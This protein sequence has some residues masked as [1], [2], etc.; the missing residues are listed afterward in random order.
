MPFGLFN[1]PA[2][3]L[4]YINKILAKKFDIFVIVYLDNILIYTY[5]TVNLVNTLGWLRGMLSVNGRS[6][7]I[8]HVL[9]L[10]I[11]GALKKLCFWQ[12]RKKVF[13]QLNFASEL[14]YTKATCKGHRIRSCA[15]V[16]GWSYVQGSQDEI[17]CKSHRIRSRVKG[18]RV[19][20]GD[21]HLEM[22]EVQKWRLKHKCQLV[23]RLKVNKY[24]QKLLCYLSFYINLLNIKLST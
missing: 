22:G 10:Q 16:T 4:S 8:R 1:A 21:L 5:K 12:N 2:S 24:Y 18:M 7:M 14:S 3:F 17:A 20:Q 19:A 15:G 13:N 23:V 6:Y 11:F 9:I